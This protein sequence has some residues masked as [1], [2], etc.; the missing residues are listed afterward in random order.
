MNRLAGKPNPVYFFDDM[1][2]LAASFNT[3]LQRDRGSAPFA[4]RNLAA[5]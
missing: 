2:E 5:S 3:Y 1:K 4:L